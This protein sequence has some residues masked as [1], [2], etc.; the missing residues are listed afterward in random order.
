M[1]HN[2]TVI[3]PE[4]EEPVTLATVAGDDGARRAMMPAVLDA[5]QGGSS[6]ICDLETA[7][8]QTMVVSAIHEACT[9]HPVEGETFAPDAGPAR[10]FIP[11]IE[12]AM[13]AAFDAERLLSE[14]GVSWVRRGSD[15]KIGDRKMGRGTP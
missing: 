4:A 12:E 15:R 10:T 6:F 8:R 11:G 13:R 2:G 3:R 5:V 7:A 9:I 1:T 14:S